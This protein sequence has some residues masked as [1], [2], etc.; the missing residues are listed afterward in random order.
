ME[1]NEE[2]VNVAIRIKPVFDYE[3]QNL[4]VISH[5]PPVLLLIDRSQTFT[6]NKIF[7]EDI[8]QESIYNSTVKPLVQYVKQ[9][10]NC[11]VFAYGQTG[12][13]K[14]YT[15]GTNS[16]VSNEKE[17]GL[18]PRVLNHFFE[19]ANDEDTGIEISVSYIEIYNEKVFDLLQNKPLQFKGLK[20]LGCSTEKVFNSHEARHFLNTGGKN[21]HTG[22]T[23]QNSQSSRSHA[24]FTIYCKVKHKEMVTTAKLNLVDLAGCESVKKTGSD[25]STFQEGINI[26]RGLLAIGQVMDALINNA[27]FIPYRRSI[28]TSLLQDS[29]N[30]QNF[31]SLIACVSPSIEDT[32]ETLQTLE[33]AKRV[34]KILNRPEVNEV[35]SLYRKENPMLFNGKPNT[36]FKRPLLTPIHKHKPLQPILESNYSTDTDQIHSIKSLSPNISVNS[37]MTQQL[38]SPIIKKYMNAM[39]NSLMNKMEL[40]LKT[41][42]NVQPRESGVNKENIVLETPSVNWNLI[43]NQVTKIVRSEMVQ[44]TGSIFTAT[45]SPIGEQVNN[46]RK[47]LTYDD[48]KNSDS[49]DKENGFKVPSFTVKNISKKD[50][51]VSSPKENITYRRSERLSMKRMSL[52]KTKYSDQTVLIPAKRSVRLF[53]KQAT[54]SKVNLDISAKEDLSRYSYC[55]K[56]Q[57]VILRNKT[58]K[59]KNQSTG[60][61][62]KVESS[63]TKNLTILKVPTRKKLL[64]ES[65]NDSPRTAHTKEV[66]YILNNGK[67]K[68]LLKLQTIGEKSA[69]QMTLFRKIKG[70]IN[71][72]S[73]LK[74]MP[75][76]G[77]KKFE[78]FVDQNFIKKELI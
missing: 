48:S 26:N 67:L 17:I 76:W 3:K 63:R 64:K 4:R 7:T 70:R 5:K 33:F 6:F 58:I 19:C 18:I 2:F 46:A 68:E 57:S 15:M 78:N 10:Y 61:E 36:P 50:S 38:L 28:I 30:K 24:I 1:T 72:I 37:D 8:S 52:N 49:G 55:N 31:V 44:L 53:M 14:T 12:T 75:G 43:Q 13:G 47:C 56:R 35:V 21:R 65:R 23:K 29:L 11:T 45:S 25:G 41:S 40:M 34:G 39:E 51:L 66:L 54:V 60:T 9:G 42:M 59:R 27:T 74:G 73:D 77:T 22:G 16:N 71:K 20:A 69:E 62:Q 32:T